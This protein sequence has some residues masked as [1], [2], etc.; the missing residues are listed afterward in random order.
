M[1]PPDVLTGTN[2]H[3]ATHNLNPGFEFDNHASSKATVAVF[4]ADRK[5]FHDLEL[6]R[7]FTKRAVGMSP[8]NPFPRPCLLYSDT[9]ISQTTFYSMSY[10]P[11]A[12]A[13]MPTSA[14]TW[15]L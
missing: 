7:A 4:H 13:P 9:D 12:P 5:G 1:P 6:S 11:D 14:L 2:Y 8:P 10:E 15:R 3:M